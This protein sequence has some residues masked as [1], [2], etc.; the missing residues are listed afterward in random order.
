MCDACYALVG[1]AVL[2]LRIMSHNI[3]KYVD[4][5]KSNDY[6]TES[7]LFLFRLQT[8]LAK[9]NMLLNFVSKQ[10]LICSNNIR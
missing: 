7:G 4:I 10:Q 8:S 1:D 2:E 6:A 3:T 5:L 9:L